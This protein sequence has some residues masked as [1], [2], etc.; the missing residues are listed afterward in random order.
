MPSQFCKIPKFLKTYGLDSP[1]QDLAKA[2]DGKTEVRSIGK[3]GGK[4][5]SHLP[6]EFQK[7]LDAYNKDRR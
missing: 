5:G 7:A 6:P 4:A 3:K 1:N 2:G